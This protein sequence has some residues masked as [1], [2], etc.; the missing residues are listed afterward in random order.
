M[1]YFPE[2]P[3]PIS[4]PSRE[5]IKKSA[6]GAQRKDVWFDSKHLRIDEQ[7]RYPIRTAFIKTVWN[8][9]EALY[10]VLKGCINLFN[11]YHLVLRRE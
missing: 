6:S 11:A 8:T 5:A 10:I 9:D 2:Q 4:F 7:G 1:V 3:L